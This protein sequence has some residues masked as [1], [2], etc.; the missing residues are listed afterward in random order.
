MPRL[1]VP[2]SPFDQKVLLRQVAAGD[3]PAFRTLYGIYNHRL[4][5]YISRIV[6]SEQVAE[7]LVADVFIKIWRGR[8]IITKIDNF[9]AFLFRVAYNKSVDFLR[10]ASRDARLKALLWSRIESPA[11][12][13][14]GILLKE[15]EERLR[16]AIDLLSPQRRKVYDMRR[17][18]EY[19]HDQIAEKLHISRATVNNHIV[20]AQKFIRTY[21]SSGPFEGT[22]LLVIHVLFFHAA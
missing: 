7:E 5:L 17:S 14:E 3:E 12:A 11:A 19:T 4:Y 1:Q 21:L 9:E 6:K 18:L 8:E 16:T 13:D 22:L 20:E 15:F 10:S 2:E